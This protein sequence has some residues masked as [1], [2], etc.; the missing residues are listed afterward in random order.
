MWFFLI[1]P[2]FGILH[3]SHLLIKLVTII[4]LKNTGRKMKRSDNPEKTWEVNGRLFRGWLKLQQIKSDQ[5]PEE[6]ILYE[7]IYLF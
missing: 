1:Q 4:Q 2:G 7:F 3:H 5:G 6:K